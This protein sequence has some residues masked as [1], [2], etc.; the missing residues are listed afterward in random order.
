LC[1][2]EEFFE[3][4]VELFVLVNSTSLALQ[5][6]DTDLHLAGTSVGNLTTSIAALRSD[7]SF[8]RLFARAKLRCEELNIDMVKAKDKP[9]KR[10]VS[11][12][13]QGCMLSSFLTH[14]SDAVPFNSAEEELENRTKL[15]FFLPV[16]DAA[17]S[18]IERRFNAE[19]LSVLKHISSLMAKGENFENAVRQLCSIAKLDGDLC[20]AEG[21]LL[22]YNE[23]YR[24]VDSALKSM[25][26]LQCL[27]TTMVTSKHNLLYKHFYQLV[28]FLLTLPVTSASCERAHSKVDIVRSAVRSSMTSERLEDFI[29]ISSE[30]T[31]LDG[32]DLAVI[33]DKFAATARALPL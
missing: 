5:S 11:T 13:L 24:S 28:V 16:I 19:C 4:L 21:N 31:V 14:S 15:D 3:F 29:L 22:F 9:R 7:A 27:A 32:I 23:A 20:V 8:K 33:V 12:G 18:S 6:K 10:K 2:S 25:S 1:K 26:S 30:K 17:S